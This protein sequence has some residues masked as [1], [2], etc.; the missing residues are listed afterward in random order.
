V[1]AADHDQHR[2]RIDLVQ[3]R[4]VPPGLSAQAPGRIF[5]SLPAGL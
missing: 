2:A 3:C 5:L 1:E 4:G